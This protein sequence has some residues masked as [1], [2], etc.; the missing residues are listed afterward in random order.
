MRLK[1]DLAEL[2]SE[3]PT[4]ELDEDSGGESMFIDEDNR[5]EFL[6]E[7]AEWFR[8]RVDA[9][10]GEIQYGGNDDDY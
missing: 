4:S 8:G 2:M 5:D 6:D 10:L 7:M 9:E 3:F 1:L